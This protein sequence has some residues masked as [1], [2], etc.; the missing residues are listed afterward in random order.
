M[1]FLKKPAIFIAV[2]LVLALAAPVPA[3]SAPPRLVLQITVDQLR[4][5]LPGRYVD[6]LTEGGFRY[7]MEKGTWY[8][9]AH[10]TQP[11][12]LHLFRRAGCP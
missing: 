6:R 11:A 5:D 2:L 9:D 3:A 12:R 1:K 8:I 4:G 7:L 10:Y